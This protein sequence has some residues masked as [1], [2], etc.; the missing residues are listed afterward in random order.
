M[1]STIKYDKKDALIFCDE[2]GHHMLH[3][4]LS[5]IIAIYSSLGVAIKEQLCKTDE[6][7]KAFN[8]CLEILL[9]D[10]PRK[11]IRDEVINKIKRAF[12]TLDKED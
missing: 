7:I 6:D 1:K 4:E 10:D 5:S 9:S 2:S 12:E 3:G 8:H 11:T